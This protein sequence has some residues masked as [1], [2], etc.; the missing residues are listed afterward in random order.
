MQDGRQIKATLTA[1][2]KEALTQFAWRQVEVSDDS[3]RVDIVEPSP[4]KVL[5]AYKVKGA[6][7]KFFEITVKE[8]HA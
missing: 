1:L 7:V 5:V 4:N 8:S 3:V 2:I 6:P